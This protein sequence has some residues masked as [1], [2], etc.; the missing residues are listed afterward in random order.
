M[1]SEKK[2][3]LLKPIDPAFLEEARKRALD[4]LPLTE[5]Q[6]A[7]FA[8][9]WGRQTNLPKNLRSL[10]TGIIWES[11]WVLTNLL[12]GYLDFISRSVTKSNPE[13]SDILASLKDKLIIEPGLGIKDLITLI[14]DVQINTKLRDKLALTLTILDFGLSGF[15]IVSA[16]L[17]KQSGYIETSLTL[18][19]DG[20]LSIQESVVASKALGEE[21]HGILSQGDIDFGIEI[22][23]PSEL[24]PPDNFNS[25]E[26]GF[27]TPRV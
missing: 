5:A 6:R 26:V 7:E 13:Y 10:G 1:S 3:K 4:C 25:A 11:G 22:S 17:A 23:I 14:N 8:I 20:G 12:P 27:V 21:Q 9:L 24:L 19:S 18:I 2:P 15:P 16:I